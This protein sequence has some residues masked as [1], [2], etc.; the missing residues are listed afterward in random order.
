MS[1]GIIA[2]HA[3]LIVIDAATAGLAV[4]MAQLVDAVL[5]ADEELRRELTTMGKIYEPASE[6]RFQR[7]DQRPER[8]HPTSPKRSRK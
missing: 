4:A 7:F 6:P 5:A 2:H 8:T 1:R 3:T